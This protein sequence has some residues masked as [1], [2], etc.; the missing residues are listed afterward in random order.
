[1]KG[2]KWVSPVLFSRTG[3]LAF[4]SV[5]SFSIKY[6]RLQEALGLRSC[7][8]MIHNIGRNVYFFIKKIIVFSAR[9]QSKV[10]KHVPGYLLSNNKKQRTAANQ[11]ET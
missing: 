11:A 5:V 9:I 3:K 2:V 8:Y 6:D 1:M 4:I 7:N 10:R